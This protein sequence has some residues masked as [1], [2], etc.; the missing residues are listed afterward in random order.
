MINEL[1]NI[2]KLGLTTSFD[3]EQVKEPR[4]KIKL[5]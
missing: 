5:K 4:E 3:F 2:L 1:N